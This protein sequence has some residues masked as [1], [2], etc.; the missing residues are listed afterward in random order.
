MFASLSFLYPSGGEKGGWRWLGLLSKTSQE[1]QEFRA[2]N[3]SHCYSPSTEALGFIMVGRGAR[4]GQ[5]LY[6]RSSG[7]S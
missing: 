5:P 6:S 1:A 3:S 2:E 7:Q 4:S